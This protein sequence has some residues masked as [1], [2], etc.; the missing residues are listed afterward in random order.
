METDGSRLKRKPEVRPSCEMLPLLTSDIGVRSEWRL[1]RQSTSSCERLHL[2]LWAL[3]C[4][5]PRRPR[6]A[7]SVTEDGAALAVR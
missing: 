7:A 2:R 6:V 1:G 5:S 3:H 4:Q